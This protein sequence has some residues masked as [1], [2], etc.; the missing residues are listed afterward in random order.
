M[1]YKNTM[2][3][4]ILTLPLH[5][6]YGGIL[7]AYALQ[8]VLERMGHEVVVFDK[9]T[10]VTPPPMWKR[11][12]S[13]SKRLLRKM[14]GR[15]KGE[16]LTYSKNK[17]I[18]CE[19]KFTQPFIDKYIHRAIVQRLGQSLQLDLDAIVVGSDQVW[20]SFYFRGFWGTNMND[21]FLNFCG[22]RQIRKVAYAASFGTDKW[23]YTDEETRQCAELIKNFDFVSTRELSG[24][25]LCRDYLKYNNCRA[26]LDPTM[27]LEKEDYIQ[28]FRHSNT[29]RS[30]GDLMTYVL[31]EDERKLAFVKAVS[32]KRGLRVFRAN[33]QVENHNADMSKR[34]QPPV[35]NWLRGFYDAK[36]VITDSFHACVFSILFNKP[37]LVIGNEKRGL[38]R[39][40]SLLKMFHLESFLI[41][42]M[43]VFDDNNADYHW[44][45]VNSI[46]ESKREECK[47]LLS[48]SLL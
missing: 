4:G 46:L 25:Q 2:R 21:A 7:Q 34:C 3:I 22:D 15:Y 43:G 6:N 28:L 19:R 23:E 41:T 42:D 35:E 47:E 5:T 38:S 27:L 33:S 30:A 17:R 45:R 14:L 16:I 8:T 40:E 9:P 12:L 31:D 32:K 18:L 24:V 20:R 29:P 26:V 10:L 13:Y 39:F 37:F 11:P 44:E 1:V 36:L 48:K